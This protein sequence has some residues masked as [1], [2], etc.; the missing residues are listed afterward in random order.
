MRA[1]DLGLGAAVSALVGDA[2]GSAT[3]I[4]IP[5]GPNP[6]I[7]V[8]RYPARAAATSVRRYVVPESIRMRGVLGV[9]GVIARVGGMRVAPGSLT[10]GGDET[11]VPELQ[12]TLGIAKMAF[13]VHLG[14]PRA[15]RK[16]VLHVMDEAGRSIAYA[17]LGVNALTC[18]RVRH[19]A[20]ALR[21]LGQVDTPGLITPDLLATGKWRGFDYLV[22]APLPNESGQVPDGRARARANRALVS[23][24][25]ITERPLA[26]SEWWLQAMSELA[27]CDGSDE[28]VSLR[29]A[30]DCLIRRHGE[31]V[32]ALG[33]AHGD[34]SRWN[35]CATPTD[36]VAWDWE[37]FQLA[38]PI[39]WDELHFTI[40]AHPEGVAGALR[41]PRLIAGQALID[42]DG[43]VAELLLATYLVNRG[44]AYLVDGQREAG[45]R[46]G[47]LGSW[48]LPALD[49][50]I[51]LG[52]AR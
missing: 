28:A 20:E 17:K 49:E 11:F 3:H 7:L 32:M 10:L 45:A 51:E 27:E 37:R 33:A 22:M 30:A 26:R 42:T 14:P 1:V 6:R 18:S 41:D 50:L 8:P 47:P 40:G 52:G 39:G 25:P 44:I 46:T 21:R 9:G 38:L 2:G 5:P 48:L 15:N 4:A 16:P 43:P 23:A 29:R 12:Q 36:I 24:F 31:V 34:W 19:E 35:V 13:A